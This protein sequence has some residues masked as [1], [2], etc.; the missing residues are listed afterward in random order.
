MRQA[1]AE[2][3]S[4]QAVHWSSRCFLGAGGC[5]CPGCVLAQVPDTRAQR[6]TQRQLVPLLEWSV[7]LPKPPSNFSQ[8]AAF[9]PAPEQASVVL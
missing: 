4:P 2:L 1:R 5:L 3:R 9:C 8:M 6:E 7:T